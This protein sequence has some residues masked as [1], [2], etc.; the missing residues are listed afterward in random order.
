LSDKITYKQFILSFFLG[1]NN[2]R[3]R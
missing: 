3:R 2:E 1:S